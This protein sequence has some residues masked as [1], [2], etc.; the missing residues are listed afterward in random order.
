MSKA[1]EDG[2]YIPKIIKELELKNYH[3]QKKIMQYIIAYN[4]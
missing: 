2:I 3:E 4:I 1:F